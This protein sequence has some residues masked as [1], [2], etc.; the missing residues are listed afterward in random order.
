MNLVTQPPSLFAVYFVGFVYH[1]T[2]TYDIA[3]WVFGGFVVLAILLISAVRVEPEP[4][5]DDRSAVGAR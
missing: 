3:F 5:P 1:R 4:G 2:G